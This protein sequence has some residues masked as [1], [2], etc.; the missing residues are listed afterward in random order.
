MM[1]LQRRFRSGEIPKA[2]YIE[3]MYQ[4]HRRLFDYA[5]LLAGCPVHQLVLDQ[6]G[7]QA[8][9][10]TGLKFRL[11][12]QDRRQPPIEALN[13]GS[14]EGDDEQMLHALT[15]PGDTVFDV[16]ANIGWHAL[17]LGQLNPAGMVV[18]FEP[19]LST[20]AGLEANV[21]LNNISNITILPIGLGET[22]ETLTLFLDESMPMGASA[23]DHSGGGVT[24]QVGCKIRR[25]DDVSAELG[26]LPDLVKIDVEGAE[27]FVIR[28]GLATLRSARPVVA[29]ELLRK[30]AGSFGYHP[31]EV[32]DLMTSLGYRCFEA[33]GDRLRLVPGITDSTVATNFFFLHTEK[34]AG[35]LDMFAR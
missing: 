15:S 13:F 20:F 7:V 6:T 17:H 14:F 31:N 10:R 9:T 3:A 25:L 18:A 26:I 33:D 8:V 29:C 24:M 1:S 34:H 11:D 35:L 12:P 2:D 22:E 19:V 16:G 30:W 23:V 21:A 32:I 4:Q 28:G 27:M 5:G